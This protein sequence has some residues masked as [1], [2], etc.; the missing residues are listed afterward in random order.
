MATRDEINSFAS[1]AF[2]RLDDGNT[3]L[4]MD[5]LYDMWRRENP[6]PAAFAENAAAVQAAIDDF[7]RGDRGGPA[8]ELS[9]NLRRTI[10]AASDE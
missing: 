4:S 7:N 3:D 6:D 8:G 10:D 9:R 2:G 1:F 5:E